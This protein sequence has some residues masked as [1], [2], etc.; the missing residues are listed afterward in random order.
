MFGIAGNEDGFGDPLRGALSGALSA[1]TTQVVRGT[2]L[3]GGNPIVRWVLD[4]F[5]GPAID[6]NLG[7]L[8]VV[9][10]SPFGAG[11]PF[12]AALVMTG[13]FLTVA[14]VAWRIAV[15]YGAAERRAA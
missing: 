6:V 12:R 7:P 9:T 11:N 2:V 14:F 5:G 4:T 15:S 8:G 10:V 3:R 1:A 13:A